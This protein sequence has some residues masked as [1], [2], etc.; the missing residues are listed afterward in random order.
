[1]RGEELLGFGI[2]D[3]ILT[4]ELDVMEASSTVSAGSG[5]DLS[6]V[7]QVSAAMPALS[8]ASRA[9]SGASGCGGDGC[10]LPL[11][12]IQLSHSLQTVH[13]GLP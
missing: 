10:P 5:H 6:R 2:S 13:V 3:E 8:Y 11:G 1:M 12:C 9:S 7:R 4:I